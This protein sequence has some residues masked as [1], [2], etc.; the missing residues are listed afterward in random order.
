M[1]K[2]YRSR[3][4]RPYVCNDYIA[5]S[6]ICG[7]KIKIDIQLDFLDY[8]LITWR[9]YEGFGHLWSTLLY[10][11]NITKLS[12]FT[13]CPP[14]IE[15]RKECAQKLYVRLGMRPSGTPRSQV[16][17]ISILL[18]EWVMRGKKSIQRAKVQVTFR[19]SYWW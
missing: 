2:R 10:I 17:C 3:V 12:I 6:K 1:Y 16:I 18:Q 4:K 19:T 15:Q 5:S 8:I 9:F 14:R 11:L 7:Y 13:V